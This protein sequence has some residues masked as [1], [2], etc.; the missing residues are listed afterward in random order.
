[1]ETGRFDVNLYLVYCYI[2]TCTCCVLF[3][4]YMYMLCIIQSA[5]V[6]TELIHVHIMLIDVLHKYY[7]GVWSHMNIASL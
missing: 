6:V 4:L 3:N 2:C 1:M 7:K 5:L